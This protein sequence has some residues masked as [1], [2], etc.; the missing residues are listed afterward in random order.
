MWLYFIIYLSCSPLSSHYLPCIHLITKAT[1]LTSRQLQTPPL[2]LKSVKQCLPRTTLYC[3][4]LAQR[5]SLQ[6]AAQKSAV[7]IDRS[8]NMH[9]CES[10]THKLLFLVQNKYANNNRS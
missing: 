8:A 7:Q 6:N 9:T 1:L 3:Q 10:S 5:W 4:E 2:Q